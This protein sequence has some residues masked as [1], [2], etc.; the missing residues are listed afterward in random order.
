MQ[1][2]QQQ[3]QQQTAAVAIMKSGVVALYK[4]A[5]IDSLRDMVKSKRI[6]LLLAYQA[7]IQ[8]DSPAATLPTAR[9]GLA[10]FVSALCTCCELLI[11]RPSVF[12]NYST[13]TASSLATLD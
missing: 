11:Y 7:F 3:R 13:D 8:V 12:V 6:N 2:Q 1:Q 5:V 9:P 10:C 4:T